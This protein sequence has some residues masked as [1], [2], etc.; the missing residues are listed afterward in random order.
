MQAGQQVES[1]DGLAA[2]ES[3]PDAAA[4][5]ALEANRR[6]REEEDN[7]AFG[8]DGSEQKS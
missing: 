6:R 1:V 8:A 7:V 3:E 2:A 5:E 4:L